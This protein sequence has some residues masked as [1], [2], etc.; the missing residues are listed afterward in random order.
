[1]AIIL[2]DKE[3][4]DLIQEQKPLPPDYRA[5]IQLRPKLGHKER[6]LDLDGDKGNEF[7]LIL[8]QSAINPLDFSVILAYRLPKS[9]QLFRLCRYNGKSHEHSNIIEE[10]K[11][12]GFHIHQATFRYQESGSNEDAYAEPTNRFS[13]FNQALSCM[14]KDCGFQV[15]IEA[16]GRLFEEV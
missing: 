8:R 4:A 7:R 11:F 5:R 16:Q 13:D 15:P 2:S 12:Y 14:L 6:E 3:I 9:N 1:M 10:E